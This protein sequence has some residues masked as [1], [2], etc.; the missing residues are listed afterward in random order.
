LVAAATATVV[1]TAG[2][3]TSVSASVTTSVVNVLTVASPLE[4]CV[5]YINKYTHLTNFSAIFCQFNAN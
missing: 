2:V 3:A 1:T 4:S 5:T